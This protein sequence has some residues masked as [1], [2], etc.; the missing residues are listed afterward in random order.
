MTRSFLLALVVFATSL[1]CSHSVNVAPR[2]REMLYIFPDSPTLFVVDPSAGRVIAAPGPVPHGRLAP[3]FSSDSSTLFFAAGDSSEDGIFALDSRSLAIHRVL[4][5]RHSSRRSADSL[6]VFGAL[7]AIAPNAAELYDGSAE[8]HDRPGQ[9]P[10]YTQ[11][12]AKID[13]TSGEVSVASDPLSIMSLTPLPAGPVAPK[14]ALIVLPLGYPRDRTTLGWLVL[15]DPVSRK[16]LDSL[17]VP[18]YMPGTEPADSVPYVTEYARSVVPAPDGRHVYVLGWDGIYGY[19]LVT[20][21][22]FAVVRAPSYNGHLALS[23][24][25][26]TVYFVED[27]VLPSPMIVSRAPAVP[28]P[29]VA[30]PSS[31]I[32]VFDASLVEGQSIPFGVQFAPKTPSTRPYAI[33]VSRDNMALYLTAS[34]PG[35][36]GNGILHVLV[37]NLATG[38]IVHDIPLR[39][40]GAATVFVGH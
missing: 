16:V 22:L 27:V 40:R 26:R 18:K 25:G 6:K 9:Y 13:A 1:A 11:R 39:V 4:D 29:P 35:A 31:K 20:R 15:F 5:L 33:A 36:L 23:P 12:I 14:G 37:L 34:T 7:L 3:V 19:D 30:A 17:A 8:V 10:E 28:T 32:R 21:H 2:A 24:D 38:R